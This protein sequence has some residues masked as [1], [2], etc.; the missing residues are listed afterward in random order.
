[1]LRTCVRRACATSPATSTG[2]VPSGVAQRPLPRTASRPAAFARTGTGFG[3]AASAT[4]GGGSGR[5]VPPPV[6]GRGGQPVSGGAAASGRSTR[7]AAVRFGAG[8]GVCRG[9]GRGAAVGVVGAGVSTVTV[10]TGAAFSSA[11]G[12]TLAAPATPAS[13]V[14]AATAH[15]RRSA[16]V[17]T[18]L[19]H[20]GRGSQCTG[21]RWPF[22]QVRAVV[23]PRLV[24]SGPRPPSARSG[25]SVLGRA[26][27]SRPAVPPAPASARPLPRRRR[28]R[29]PRAVRG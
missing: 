11:E 4:V 12:E 16:A 3:S 28:R 15:R 7:G 25:G 1:M 27:P 13:R 21:E 5:G 8:R 10:T 9:V 2:R 26:G 24:P 14:P 18:A 22:R 17:S 29:A 23:S 19:P 20:G 6:R